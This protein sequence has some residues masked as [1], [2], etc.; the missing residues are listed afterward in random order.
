LTW[1]PPAEARLG[2]A[3]AIETLGL[4]TFSAAD[5]ADGDDDDAEFVPIEQRPT[6]LLVFGE[7][8]RELITSDTALW[9]ARALTGAP[10]AAGVHA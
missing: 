2:D 7:H 3:T 4:A 6:V 10:L 9:L 5:V 8:A 1:T